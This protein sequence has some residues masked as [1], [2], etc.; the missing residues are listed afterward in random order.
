M[1]NGFVVTTIMNREDKAFAEFAAKVT[2]LAAPP[3]KEPAGFVDFTAALSLELSRLKHHC[4]SF[5]LKEKHKSILLVKN[6]TEHTPSEIFKWM[7]DRC[8]SFRNISRVVPLDLISKFD[9]AGIRSFVMENRRRGSFKILFEGRLC[10]E[11]LKSEVFKVILP[12]VDA[13]VD[14]THP[15]FVVVVQAFKSLV[16]LCIIENDPRNFNFSTAASNPG[17]A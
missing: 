6:Q 15:D 9:E 7:R 3:N 12:L 11:D 8:V 10:P 17:E 16:G 5:I 2:G 4:Q 14:L 1:F 13:K